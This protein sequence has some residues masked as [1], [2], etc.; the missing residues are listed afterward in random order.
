MGDA[1]VGWATVG[2]ASA[3]AGLL[4]AAIWAGKKAAE[5][6]KQQIVE[7]RDIDERHIANQQAIERHHRVLDRLRGMR[8]STVRPSIRSSHRRHRPRVR[9][10]I[11]PDRPSSH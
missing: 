2:V 10:Y 11:F 1:F 5:G 4:V 7:Q 8:R 3:T 9:R 6:V